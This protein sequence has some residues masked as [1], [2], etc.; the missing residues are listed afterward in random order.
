MKKFLGSILLFT[1]I[2]INLNSAQI[3]SAE[4]VLDKIVSI[5]QVV[6]DISLGE[7]KNYLSEHNLRDVKERYEV[8]LHFMR[9][10]FKVFNLNSNE[11]LEKAFT[12]ADFTLMY[13]L[14]ENFY[15]MYELLENNPQEFIEY[16]KNC[17]WLEMGV[18]SEEDKIS[19]D[20]LM[21]KYQLIFQILF[22]QEDPYR[23]S[24]FALS[25]GNRIFEY[26]FNPETFPEF[27]NILSNSKLHTIG[28]FLFLC[29][30]E[31][32]ISI[33]WIWWH[34]DCINELKRLHDEGT[35]LVYIAGGPDIYQLIKNEIYN[36]RI[37]DPVLPT[38]IKYY[39][40]GWEWLVK[41][42]IGDELEFV[43]DERKIVLKRAEYKSS[44]IFRMPVCVE[45]LKRHPE[46]INSHPELLG[47]NMIELPK[48]EIVWQVYDKSWV[49]KEE[50]T[51]SGKTK[52][53]KKKRN[54]LLGQIVYERRYCEQADFVAKKDQ[55]LVMSFT[56]L[57][58]MLDSPQKGGWGI[59]AS[60]FD[61]DIKMFVK[62][63]R[64]PIDVQ[65]MRNL[66]YTLEHQDDLAFIMLWTD[67]T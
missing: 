12:N 43:F 46:I 49:E 62:Q 55:V 11:Q 27:K 41:G 6:P 17:G 2:N 26:C 16:L 40:S 66:Q 52:T 39:S 20:V 64:R 15:L 3:R 44:G 53:I 58:T 32:L 30:H 61:Y 18:N 23:F 51:K 33:P 8:N 25:F 65:I 45:N 56:E 34:Q 48:A 7:M 13:Q 54:K 47:A 38:Q 9:T 5:G 14:R 22:G 60:K 28:R 31:Y 4:D 57:N 42:G 63:L 36:V 21:H 19:A 35:E 29:L 50:T 1:L 10:L 59:D 67:P 37:I 24:K